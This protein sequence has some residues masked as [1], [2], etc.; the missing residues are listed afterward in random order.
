MKCRRDPVR[1]GAADCALLRQVRLRVV[2][3]PDR[4][5]PERGTVT[6]RSDRSS[7]L[8]AR[9]LRCPVPTEQQDRRQSIDRVSIT[10]LP[11]HPPMDSTHIIPTRP[12]PPSL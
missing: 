7:H 9:P 11:S 1:H 5:T 8:S 10:W 6:Q 3:T 4:R 2:G 12:A